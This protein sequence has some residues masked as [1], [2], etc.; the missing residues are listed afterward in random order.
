MAQSLTRDPFSRW[1][2]SSGGCLIELLFQPTHLLLHA[3]PF[4]LQ[5][6]SVVPEGARSRSARSARSRHPR[7]VDASGDSVLFVDFGPHLLCQNSQ[8]G[9][10]PAIQQ[11]E[12]SE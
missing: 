8:T 10:R 7:S 5:S 9:T 4:A 1:H 11:S 6:I 12:A 3:L 2:C